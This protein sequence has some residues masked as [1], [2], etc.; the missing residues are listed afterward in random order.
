MNLAKMGLGAM[1]NAQYKLSTA[2]HNVNNAAV[3][4]YNRQTVLSQTAGSQP[5]GGGYVGRGV[6]TVTVN[7]SYDN[8]LFTQ[9]VGALGQG[10][11][12][13]SYGNEIE[14][15]DT[16]FADTSV[17]ISPAIERFFASVNAVASEPADSAA[18]EEMLGQANNL[19][20]QVRETNAYLDQQRDNINTQIT[21]VVEQVNSYVER[22]SEANQQ[23][24]KARASANRHEPNDLLDQRDQLV[25]ELNELV[26]VKVFDQGDGR[27]S[28][29]V[30]NGQVVLGGNTVY[31]LQA[32]RSGDDPQRIVVGLTVRDSTGAPVGI[33]MDESYIRGGKLG[34][35][36]EYRQEVLDDVQ[37]NLGRMALGL[38]EAFNAVHTQGLDSQGN[39]GQNFFSIGALKTIPSVADE[40]NAANVTA[41]VVNVNDLTAAD[42]RVSVNGDGHYEIT[43]LVTKQTYPPAVDASGGAAVTRVIE[44]VEFTFSQPGVA[45]DSWLVQPSRNAAAGLNVVITDPAQIAAAA[46]GTGVSNGDIGLKL[47]QLQHDKTL[48]GGTMSVTESF[49]QIVN[50][51]GVSSQ[52]NKTALQAQQNLINQTYAAQQQVSGVNL[53]EE[54]INIEQALEQYRAASRM[55]DVS[56]TMFDTLLNMR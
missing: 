35:L 17:G 16:L 31:P 27:V 11:A 38:S 55:I 22:I 21:T 39:P 23:I 8:F 37:N 44:G 19:A 26:G 46:V 33:E 2:A 18:R 47:A 29:A 49:S 32:M 43:N 1:N 36:V 24:V 6:E 14:R 25:R 3:E 30:G 51:I 10:A 7:R 15:L 28:L 42:Y 52:K 48:G 45:G 34:G 40:A 56:S 13:T 53:N 50:R 54:Y 4:G 20:T 41:A 5:M 12:R 9:L